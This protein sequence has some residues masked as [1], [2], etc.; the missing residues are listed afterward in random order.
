MATRLRTLKGS[1]ILSI[2][3]VPEI[4]ETFAGF[5]MDQ[6]ELRYSVSSGKGQLAKELI[7]GPA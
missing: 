4:R 7:I 6:V 3:D 5:S 1:F 2:N